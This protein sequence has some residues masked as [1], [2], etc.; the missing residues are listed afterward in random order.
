MSDVP[1]DGALSALSALAE[2]A[3]A[4]ITSASSAEQLSE[5]ERTYVGKKGAIRKHMASLG[6]LSPEE[7]PAFGKAVN[8]AAQRVEACLEERKAALKAEARAV[9]LEAPDFDPTLPGTAHKAG[10]LHPLTLIDWR[11]DEI[12]RSMGFYVLDYPEADTEYFNF[13]GLNIPADHPARDMQDTFWLTDG[14]LLRTHTSAGQVRAMREFK[15]PF[16][17]IFPGRVFRYESTDASHDHTFH[18][19]EGLFVTKKVS[20][21]HLI[22]SMKTLLSEVF[23]REV[24]VRLRPGYFPFVEPGFELDISCLVCGGKGCSVCKHSGW[25]ELLPCG[26]IHPNV[27]RAGGLDPEEWQGWAFGL[28]MSRLVMMRYQIEDIRHLL[29]GDVRFWA[30]FNGTGVE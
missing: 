13:E 7:R 2:E 6:R 18:Q 30:Q 8:E 24:T 4:A 3:V 9:A 21:A 16:K 20:V 29:G 27:M 10:A 11:L 12:F 22:A 26:L 17:A 28:G 19:V 25:V 1:V 5:L 23:G 15:P 14:R